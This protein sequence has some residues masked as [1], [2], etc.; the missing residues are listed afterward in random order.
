M[1]ANDTSVTCCADD[2]DELCNDPKTEVENI[3]EWLRLS[4]LTL[5]TDTTEYIVVGQKLQT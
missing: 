5:N 4:K 1:Y 3:A 2:I